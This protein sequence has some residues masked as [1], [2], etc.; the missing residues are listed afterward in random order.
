MSIYV[1]YHSPGKQDTCSGKRARKLIRWI[2]GLHAFFPISDNQHI[3]AL[4]SGFQIF[5]EHIHFP[6]H[7]NP[8]STFSKN[9]VQEKTCK[10]S[11]SLSKTFPLRELAGSF[12][13]VPADAQA[14]EQPDLRLN[15][16]HQEMH[17]DRCW[18]KQRQNEQTGP[19]LNEES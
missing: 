13:F 5:I 15:L 19:G 2:R 1:Y 4:T 6:T 16:E 18:E 9:Q 7:C 17:W 14:F 11:K 8:N 12:W 10:S 3:I